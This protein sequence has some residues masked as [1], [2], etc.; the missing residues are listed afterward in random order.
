[1]IESPFADPGVP[2]SQLKKG[3]GS[4]PD[5]TSPDK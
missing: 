4:E 5:P 3:T 2:D 1:M